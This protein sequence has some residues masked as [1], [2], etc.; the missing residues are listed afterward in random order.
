MEGQSQGQTGD[1]ETE[2]REGDTE[3]RERS[4]EMN[5]GEARHG[6]NQKGPS[7]GTPLTFDQL[8]K[9]AGF[10]SLEPLKLTCPEV[11]LHQ[12]TL[13][14]PD[15]KNYFSLDVRM[16]ALVSQPLSKYLNPCPGWLSI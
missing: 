6:K 5:A 15:P 8:K 1:R 9:E 7:P 11:R 14:Y 3:G 2:G 16:S 12:R 13:E 4:G 10:C